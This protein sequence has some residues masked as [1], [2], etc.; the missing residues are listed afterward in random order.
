VTTAG[1]ARNL[2]CVFRSPKKAADWK[3]EL[4]REKALRLRHERW[5]TDS[6]HLFKVARKLIIG[7][8]LLRHGVDLEHTL[9]TVIGNPDHALDVL[10]NPSFPRRILR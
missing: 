8:L 5:R 10:T 6:L 4:A 7:W 3:Q 9:L 1:L 2:G